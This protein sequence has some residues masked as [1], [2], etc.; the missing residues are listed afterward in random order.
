MWRLIVLGLVIGVVLDC[1]ADCNICAAVT[2]TACVSDTQFEFCVNNNPN[3]TRYTCPS[4]LYCTAEPTICQTDSSLK[5]CVGCGQC[6][7]EGIFACLGVRTF[8]LCLGSSSPSA[9]TGTCAP[10]HVCNWDNPNI[11]GTADAG[12]QA[13]C[14]L[15]DDELS[16]TVTPSGN[17]C[18]NEYCRLI[19]QAGR[20]PYGNDLGTS[21]KKY[22]SCFQSNNG[23]WYGA[24]Y[25]CPGSTYFQPTPQICNTTIPATCTTAVRSLQLY[26]LRLL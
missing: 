17:L 22:I 8:A 12:Y 13:T 7:T 4:G 6:N 14:P 25:T 16:T 18:P 15:A 9:L 5:A 21:C 26:N 1:R 20:F 19:Q 3:G 24:L 11:C 2:N 10:N 23:T